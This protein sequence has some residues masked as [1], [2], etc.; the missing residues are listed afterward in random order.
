[1]TS[2][3][4]RFETRRFGT[5][6]EYSIT[7]TSSSEGPFG[8]G[9]ARGECAGAPGIAGDTGARELDPIP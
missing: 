6:V 5:M 4:F 7:S 1:M 2:F 3:P 9:N 8:F